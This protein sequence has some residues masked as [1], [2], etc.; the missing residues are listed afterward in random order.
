[1]QAQSLEAE[2]TR[3]RQRKQTEKKTSQTHASKHSRQTLRAVSELNLGGRC[4]V[5]EVPLQRS[6]DLKQTRAIRR[7]RQGIGVQLPLSKKHHQWS[8]ELTLPPRSVKR[9][10]R[11][12]RLC[13]MRGNRGILSSAQSGGDSHQRQG[14][15]VEMRTETRNRQWKMPK[16]PTWTSL[17]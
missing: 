8:F 9:F 12:T 7:D 11:E 14:V 10:Y 15:C 2:T 1:M 4:S 5:A 17:I 6:I 13:N 3:A 16:E